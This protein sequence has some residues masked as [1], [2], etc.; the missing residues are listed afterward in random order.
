MRIY[1][2]QGVAPFQC[3]PLS[4][5]APRSLRIFVYPLPA[6]FNTRVIEH[7]L[8]HPPDM[9]DPV[10]TTSFYSSEWAFHQLLLDSPLRTL[11][12]RDADYYYVPVYGTCHGFNRMAVQPNASAE[13]FS[14]ALDWITSHGSIPRDTLPWRYDPYSP[15]WNSLGTIEQVATRGEYPPFPAFAQDHLWLFSQGHG[16]K[17]FGDYSRIKNAVFL[18]AN[19]QLSA[20][21]F[22]LAKD[23]TI[24]P[25]LTHYVPTPIYANKSVDELEVILTGQRPTL[26]CFGGTKLPCFV[27]DARGS[28][29]SRGVRPYLKETFSKH[30]D[31]RILGIR[32]SGYEKALRSST[33]CLCPE[34]WHAWTPRVFE[35]ILSGCIPVLISDDLALPFESL[36]DYDA[37]IVRIPPA[38]V[39]ADLLSTLQSISHQDVHGDAFCSILEQLYLKKRQASRRW[40]DQKDVEFRRWV[41]A[42]GSP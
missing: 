9:R 33:F 10:C 18:T 8:A 38:R 20:A 23:V 5:S 12:P 39:A 16:A 26:A 11:N 3:T 41:E 1:S 35:A 25:R 32:S 31:F 40:A 19:G 36:I 24:P 34:G 27:N 28:C 15:D 4:A 37:F 30:P 29:H 6:E 22:T 42:G 2:E 21:E 17:L 13:L 14:A 7:N